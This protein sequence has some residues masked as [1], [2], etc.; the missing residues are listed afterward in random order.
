MQNKFMG[1]RLQASWGSREASAAHAPEAAPPHAPPGCAEKS[2]EAREG[3][4]CLCAR[5]WASRQPD[6]LL[7]GLWMPNKPV[8]PAEPSRPSS[9]A[10]CAGRPHGL[11]EPVSPSARPMGLLAVPTSQGSKSNDSHLPPVLSQR[12]ETPCPGCPASCLP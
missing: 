6:N 1:V 7:G 3:P 9:L 4:R 8:C 11:G 10:H 2:Q 5:L 12:W